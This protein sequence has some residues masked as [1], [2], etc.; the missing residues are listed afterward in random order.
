MQDSIVSRGGMER[1]SGGATVQ[2]FAQGSASGREVG[3]EPGAGAKT[4]LT[5]RGEEQRLAQFAVAAEPGAGAKT[6]LTTSGGGA[7]SGLTT[8][9]E[10]QCLAQ[11][12][13]SAELRFLPLIFA[14]M[15][16]A[17]LASSLVAQER[18]ADEGKAL[19]AEVSYARDIRPILLARCVGCHQGARTEGDY[20]MTDFA[21]L[22]GEGESGRAAIVPGKPDESFLI[23]QITPVNGKAEMPT[24]GPPL[25][26]REIA[27]VRKWIEQGANNDWQRSE[28][29]FSLANPPTY[30]RL[31]TITSLDFSP[32]GKTLAVSGNH[33]VLLLDAETGTMRRRLIG[34]SPRIESVRYSPDGMR[35]AVTGGSPGEAGELQVWN[36]V[37]GDLI[38]SSFVSHDT[39]F[40][41]SWSP[42]SK[43]VAFGC[44]DTSVRVVDAESGEQL[45]FQDAADDW[46][47]DTVF[48]VDGSHLVS[49]GRD[50]ACKLTEVATERF[51]DNITSITPGVLKG[52]IAAVT[53][54]PSRDEILIGSADGMPKIYRMHRLTKRV[55]G[56]DANLIRRFPE[57]PGRVTSVDV[58][59]DGRRIVAAS[60][61]DGRGQVRVWSWEF[62][63][64][65]PDD[66]RAISGKVVTSRSPE[67]IKRLEAYV[68]SD[69]QQFAQV[70]LPQTAAYAVA[71]HPSGEYFIVGGADGQ[72]YRYRTEGG[73]AAGVIQPVEVAAAAASRLSEPWGFP[74]SEERDAKELTAEAAARAQRMESLLATGVKSLRVA[75]EQVA[76]SGRADYVQLVV[77]AELAN[78]RSLDVTEL[79]TYRPAAGVSVTPSGLVQ[80]NEEA[81]SAASLTAGELIV[82]FGGQSTLVPVRM[83]LD[84]TAPVSFIR[85]VNPVLTKLGC[86]AGTCHGSQDGKKGF[87]LSLRGYDPVFDIRALTDD[88]ATRRVNV[89]APDESLML[90]KASA[91]VPHEGGQLF[92]PQGKYYTLIRSWIASG[93]KVDLSESR[94]QR[95]ELLPANPVLADA[96]SGQQFRV[97]AHWPDGRSRD[98]TRESFVESA[99]LE[100][101]TVSALGKATAVRRGEAALLARFDGA[102]A[103]T[104]LTVMG[105]RE[106]FIWEEPPQFNAID[107]FVAAKWKRMKIRPAG[108]CSDDEFI[109]RVYLDLTGLPPSSDQVRAFLADQ[110]ESQLK[111]NELVDRLIG[112]DEFI[113]YW[114]NKWA[115]LLQVNRKFLAPEGA[116]SFHAWIRQQVA[117]N[118]PYDQFVRAILTASGSN[119]DQ[120]AAAYYK[121]LRTPTEMM[122]NTTHL[123]LATR[124]NC[125]KCHD[126]PFERWTQDQYYQTAAWFAQV[127]LSEDPASN[128]GRIGGTDVEAPTPLFEMIADASEGEMLHDRTKQVTAPAFPYQVASATG[129][130]A[131]LPRRERLARWLTAPDN[132]YFAST[133]ANRLWGYL[134]GVG[135]IE[136]LDDV[137]ASNPPSNPEL[138][139]YLTKELVESNFNTRHL[140]AM[141]CK[142]RTYQLSVE[143][144]EWNSD[145]RTNYS[146]AVPK[147]LPAEVLYDA[148]HFVIGSRERIPGVPEGTR[149][150]ELADAGIAVPSGFFATLGKPV[151]ES[152]CECER[153]NDLQL[154][155]VLA[156]VSGPD[157]ASVIGDAQS[158]LAKL[159]AAQANDRALV[160]EL[161]LRIWSRPATDAEF[162]IFRSHGAAVQ[163][164]HAELLARR[165]ARAAEVGPKL[166]QLA[167]E[168]TAAI[169][170]AEQKLT[171]TI[172]AVDPQLAE[173][174]K[175]WAERLASAELAF[176]DYQAKQPEQFERW[177]REQLHSVQWYPLLPAAVKQTSGAA[178]E[179]L[180][181]RSVFVNESKGATVTELIAETE[182]VGLSNLRLEMLADSRLPGGGPG[183][184][185][186]VGNLVLSEL[187]VEIA[188]QSD[189]EAWRPVTIA[190]AIADFEQNGFPVALSFDA[191]KDDRRGWALYQGTGRTRWAT[192]QFQQ[193]VG[194]AGGSRLRFRLTQNF[195][196]RHQIGRFRLSLAA[197]ARPAG[198]GLSDELL[199]TLVNSSPGEEARQQVLLA[200][201]RGDN[202]RQRLE[203][204]LVAAR[205]PLAIDPKIVEARAL[206]EMSNRP[207]PP[208]PLLERL[209]R[210]LSQS[211]MQLANLRLTMAQ[212]LAWALI[213]SPAFLFNR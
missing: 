11:F 70:E 201:Q 101:A 108:L 65:L 196:E 136:P 12:A 3:A 206:L 185:P 81:V 35:L 46:V 104:T 148:L 47:R 32:D 135:L 33:E 92:T 88:M 83:A 150:T 137:R 68:T 71:F 66:I 87:K 2:R 209:Q 37:T 182:L 110:R 7:R 203:A 141:I 165:D 64:S 199:T 164:D 43:R 212:D 180:A 119:K 74:E 19:A 204:E 112:S 130:P 99:N 179:V 90:L 26:E 202:Q 173:R 36:A 152:A 122:E 158:E 138:L 84:V 107:G 17:F 91:Q 151:R 114:S 9:G 102:Y 29:N 1:F 184:S 72:L 166:E 97:V 31:P 187:E 118:V 161:Y 177:K 79:A 157:Q 25:S 77:T 16:S 42:D 73:A 181:D 98:V 140:L 139:N 131:E 146:R 186:E 189:P 95:L 13:V 133:Y 62:D 80:P 156:L 53:R 109:R 23:E 126:H 100:V 117:D 144:N 127:K 178:S 154:G 128:G 113:D 169:A 125:N 193:P 22:V 54:H 86:N 208:D 159:V 103:A 75:P 175:Q 67:E 15:M 171:E 59:S 213:N 183:L 96:D 168:R 34:A 111:R 167:A 123:F 56:D 145:D 69:L 149:A 18:P 49:V 39:I 28:Q 4:R 44:T 205:M 105:N 50:M 6:R 30:S 41:A 21:R 211:E 116:S 24:E 197:L 163:A 129:T 38:F 170:A 93:A 210:D 124:F 120:P 85:D 143:S 63:S 5:T 198:L 78:G 132:P 106:G 40:G 45:L 174:E 57:M 94:P 153:S 190:S 14:L 176:Q 8:R 115:D 194:Y 76:V 121:I 162:E 142:S 55:I 195:D 192:F 172:A 58:S 61:L 27:L 147:R 20:L 82:E 134:L 52:G 188:P 51:V 155:S 200:F 160:D 10:E 207:V 48:S 191:Q 89:A 60:S